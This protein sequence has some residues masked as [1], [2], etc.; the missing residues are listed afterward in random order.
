M[1]YLF[2][3]AITVG[4]A[5]FAGFIMFAS[6]SDGELGML[7]FWNEYQM[8]IIAGYLILSLLW[9]IPTMIL[10][11]I[12]VNWMRFSIEEDEIIIHKGIINKT[13]KHIPFRTI[14]N[15]STRY[16]IYDRF[17]R[18]GTVEIETAGK[19]AQS[20]APEGKI[21]GIRNFVEIRD[22]ILSK[23]RKYKGTYATTTEIP[24]TEADIVESESTGF[25]RE[26][27]AELKEIKKLLAK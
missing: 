25:Y 15:V 6:A 9:I 27:L 1:Y 26:M 14:T 8:T 2:F 5:A 16:G 7:N 19:S 10:I 11:P 3:F 18:I 20:L 4:I 24:E 12:Y 22:F 23:L 21:E 13:V 17:F